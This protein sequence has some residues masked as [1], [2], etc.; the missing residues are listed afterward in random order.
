MEV[1]CTFC[2]NFLKKCENTV[3]KAKVLTAQANWVCSQ[4]IGSLD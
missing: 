2:K 1:R 4:T 3:Y